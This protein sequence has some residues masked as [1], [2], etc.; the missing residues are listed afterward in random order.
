LTSSHRVLADDDRQPPVI[1]LTGSDNSPADLIVLCPQDGEPRFQNGKTGKAFPI[2]DPQLRAIAQKACQS[3]LGSE[4][5]MSVVEVTNN[6]TTT[7]GPIYVGFNGAITWQTGSGCTTYPGGVI[8][9]ANGSTCT[10]MIPTNAG[11]TRF[12]ASPTAGPLNCSMAQQNNQTLIETTFQSSCYGSNGSCIWYDI[13]VIPFNGSSPYCDNNT[14]FGSQFP[15]GSQCATSTGGPQCSGAGT[16]AYNLPVMLSCANEPTLTCQGPT[17][18]YPPV[19]YP[20]NCGMPST[21]TTNANS[22]CACGQFSC[23]DNTP[24]NCI[25]AFFYPMYAM[26][27][28]PN[29]V[30]SNGQTL[31]INLLSGQ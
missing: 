16:A 26:P 31:T 21:S 2:S 4:S 7:S 14:W 24:P 5:N 27:N 17:G 28:E 13:S 6:T 11:T 15:V 22:Q 30:C 3:F 1:H 8:E 23:K 20:S 25:A 10:A 12:C 9:I 19:N 29:P 18:L